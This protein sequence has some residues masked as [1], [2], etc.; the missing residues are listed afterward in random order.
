[1]FAYTDESGNEH[2]VWFENAA[3]IRAKLL[4]AQRLGIRGIA[5]WRLGMEDPDIW[6]MIADEFVVEKSIAP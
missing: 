4:A 5:L 2:E 6:R 1:M 3:S